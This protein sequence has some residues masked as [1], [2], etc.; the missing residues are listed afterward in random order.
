[1]YSIMYRTY[2]IIGLS[3]CLSLNLYAGNQV[4]SIAPEGV[5]AGEEN[6]CHS[7]QEAFD[8]IS[9]LEEMDT[10]H[11]RVLPG[12]YWM[13]QTLVIDQP[14]PAPVVVSGEGAEK[15]RFLAG[16][17]VEGWEPWQKGVWR[18][19]IPEVQQYG[20]AFDQFY[21]NG[22]RAQLARTPHEGWGWVT[23]SSE[24]AFQSGE[25]APEFA[26]QRISFSPQELA[27][28]AGLSPEQMKQTRFRF[29]H[30]WDITQKYCD[31]MATDSGYV[32]FNGSGMK[33][34]N[35]IGEGARY[36]IYN[37]LDLLDEPGEW[38]LDR[39]QGYIYY[40]PQAGEDLR[41]AECVAPTLRHQ[42][43]LQGKAGQPI[44]NIT[45]E[46][47]AFE[48]ASF[49]LRPGEG[50]AAQAAAPIDAAI[51]ADFAEDIHFRNC[52]I[53]HTG[54]YAIW[55]RKE[56]HRNRFEKNY[57]HD[58]GAGGIKLGDTERTDGVRPV[59]SHNVIDNNIITSAGYE[60]PS[61]VGVVLFLTSDNAVTHNEI[62]NIRYSGVSV[63]WVWGYNP[64]QPPVGGKPFV[65]PAVRNRIEYNHIHHIG[66][67]ELSDMGAV[68][69][70]GESPGT[71]VSHN[72][73]H[74]VYSYDY[75]GWGLY[76][77]EGSSDIEMSYNL[78]YRCKSGG[79][80][81]HYGRNNRIENNILAFSTTNLLQCT[82]KEAHRSFSFQH[83]VL[84]TNGEPL[85]A[86]E[87][88]NAD[89]AA[90]YNLYWDIS[91][92]EMDFGGSDFS[93][94]KKGHEPHSIQRDP[95][96]TNPLQDD[97]TFRSPKAVKRIGF[98]IFDYREAGVYGDKAWREK[99]QLPKEIED[100]F[101]EQV[102]R[103]MKK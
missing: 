40:Y 32:Y 8:R 42:I 11:L 35:P 101:V 94:W 1:M 95:L 43:L 52:E 98:Q 75:G 13:E 25:R 27:P 72:V 54:G 73:I 47:L 74:D 67:G 87:W 88:A 4:I 85:F 24:Q 97:F 17:R 26:V 15:P 21:V 33:P 76:T 46:N 55:F 93:A 19:F 14:L 103:N 99:A 36:I 41:T 66:W 92:K 65:N 44:R 63:G 49:T 84:L 45:F 16:V 59:S 86:R 58:L 70:L 39:Q 56:C 22:E 31:Y 37:Q 10:V 64:Q 23:S 9:S 30:K 83:N 90:D 18:A 38:Y 96:F 29:F 28:F 62:S 81:Q 78:V 34:W 77:D 51:Q 6:V 71:R 12:D 50:E 53:A 79:F 69:T 2:L 20:F 60:F 3:A 48:Y 102:A 7:L 5:M 61:A 89:I 57:L 68:Y 80:H 91:G 100:A 82:R